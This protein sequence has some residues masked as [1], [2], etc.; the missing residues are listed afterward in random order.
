MCIAE[1]IQ[2]ESSGSALAQTIK[3]STGAQLITKTLDKL[4]T[5]QT[6]SGPAVNADYQFQKDVLQAA[7]LGTKLDKMV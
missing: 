5:A 6:L 2:A 7:G 1:A 3:D 4:N